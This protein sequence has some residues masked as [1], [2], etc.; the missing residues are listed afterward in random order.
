MA[1]SRNGRPRTHTPPAKGKGATGVWHDDPYARLW[2]E[3]NQGRVCAAGYADR[4]DP[5]PYATN[6]GDLVCT[7]RCTD[8]GI[9]LFGETPATLI[10]ETFSEF[11]AR[12]PA[13]FQN[14]PA[15]SLSREEKRKMMNRHW[16]NTNPDAPITDINGRT[17]TRTSKTWSHVFGYSDHEPVLFVYSLLRVISWNMQVHVAGRARQR[18]RAARRRLER[19]VLSRSR[20]RGVGRAGN[21]FSR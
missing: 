12:N 6:L 9:R 20:H 8:W 2:V 7:P 11:V 10:I 18:A 17:I 4:P 1:S 19:T 15:N 5:R 14:K 16:L 13:I 21:L 3:P